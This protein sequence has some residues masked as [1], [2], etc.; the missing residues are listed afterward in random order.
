MYIF[1]GFIFE[2]LPIYDYENDVIKGC[3]VHFYDSRKLKRKWEDCERTGDF[4]SKETTTRSA[5]NTS[6][7]QKTSDMIRDM[8]K[9]V[10]VGSI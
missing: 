2:I 6:S 10:T 3:Y 8:L 1:T 4:R 5:A 9:Q 7:T